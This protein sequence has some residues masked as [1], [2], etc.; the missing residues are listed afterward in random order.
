MSET[1]GES[2]DDG[3]ATRGCRAPRRSSRRPSLG[4]TSEL[5]VPPLIYAGGIL[6]RERS[7][8]GRQSRPPDQATRG[9]ASIHP[10]RAYI[11]VLVE[12]TVAPWQASRPRSA[13][14]LS[15]RPRIS[16]SG[17]PRSSVWARW[18]V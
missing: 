9:G 2:A 11:G 16:Q 18:S 15:P 4:A 17:K 8:S 3:V 7:L 6:Q 14:A 5:H 10:G 13:P 12:V 1:A